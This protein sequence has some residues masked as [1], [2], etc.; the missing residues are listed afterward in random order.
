MLLSNSA[1]VGQT[2]THLPQRVQL[3]FAPVL[4]QV[5]DDHGVDAAAHHIPHV[6]AF[7]LGADPHAA[8]AE[9]AAIVVDGEALVRGVDRQFG[10]AIGQADVGQPLVLRQ[11]LQLAVAVGHADRADV[12]ALGEQ[13]L[14]DG[15]AM[16]LQPLG[17]GADFH[18]LGDGGDAGRQQLVAALD[19]DQAQAARANV[20]QAVEM[21]ERGNVDVVLPR[22][23]QDGLAARGR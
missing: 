8:R 22:H 13:Q 21:A 5:G 6:R 12:V 23:F 16:L 17:V 2:C 14:E 10:I 1:P 19:L 7:D 9:D 4:V 20:A 3:R 11:G 15:A 18:A